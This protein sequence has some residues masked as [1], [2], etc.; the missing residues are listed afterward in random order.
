MEEHIMVTMIMSISA[1]VWPQIAM[2]VFGGA[3]ST[4]V[5]EGIE[6]VG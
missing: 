1:A 2:Q 5:W 6:V 3:V 4:P